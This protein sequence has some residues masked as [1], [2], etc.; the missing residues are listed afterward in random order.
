MCTSAYHIINRKYMSHINIIVKNILRINDYFSFRISVWEKQNW[1]RENKWDQQ[2]EG[3]IDGREWKRFCN[4][5]SLLPLWATALVSSRISTCDTYIPIDK[6]PPKNILKIT[7]VH[8]F[9]PINVAHS[10]IA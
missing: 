8:L 10:N 1:G 7:L 2:K 4:E 9:Y 3:K 5:P 6:A